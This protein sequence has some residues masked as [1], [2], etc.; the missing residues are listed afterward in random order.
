MCH[1][2]ISVNIIA[3]RASLSPLFQASSI[4][5]L[6]SYYKFRFC[7]NTM[8]RLHVHASLPAP[9]VHTGFS[10]TQSKSHVLA[11]VQDA[12]WSDDEAVGFVVYLLE[13]IFSLTCALF[14]KED[15]ECP[16]CLEEM[17]ISDLNFKP[18][19][20]G[21]QVFLCFSSVVPHLQL[22]FYRSAVSAGTTSKRT[23]MVVAPRVVECI[24]T[25][26]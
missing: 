6:S 4:L 18:C 10:V 21:Y 22:R 7:S 15:A 2:Q 11:G 14:L 8:S 23:S 25:K 26:Q 16:L 24:P 12:Y 13:Y 5:N 19:I 17:D 20:C 1:M 9:A 3:D